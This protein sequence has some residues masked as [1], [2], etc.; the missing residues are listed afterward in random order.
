MD[1]IKLSD[2]RETDVISFAISTGG[3]LFIRVEMDLAEAASFFSTGTDVI[4]YEREGMPDRIFRG[5]TQQA[6]IV[7]ETD[8]VRV[9]LTR[10]AEYWEE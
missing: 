8:C 2:G 6:Y 3:V 1:K 4:I 10:P 9:A 7:N 5:F